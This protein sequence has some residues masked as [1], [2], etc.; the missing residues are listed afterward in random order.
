MEFHR[1][2]GACG[3]QFLHETGNIRHRTELKGGGGRGW[4]GGEVVVGGGGGGYLKLTWDLHLNSISEAK[5]RRKCQ[6]S[7]LICKHIALP[8]PLPPPLSF[9]LTHTH[10]YARTHAQIQTER[11]GGGGSF[12]KQYEDLGICGKEL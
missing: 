2:S 3:Q 7:T 11:K 4:G 12:I 1:T 9:S 5:E 10:T 6:S 8:I